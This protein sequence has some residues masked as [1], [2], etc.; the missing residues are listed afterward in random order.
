DLCTAARLPHLLAWHRGA[1][2]RPSWRPIAGLPA[3]PGRQAKWPCCRQLRLARSD[4][5]SGK[6]LPGCRTVAH[7]WASSRL[8]SRTSSPT[9][10]SA[11]TRSKPCPGWS[12][13]TSPEQGREPSDIAESLRPTYLPANTPSR[14]LH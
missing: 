4:L 6:H 5:T 12:R 9:R 10:H 11:S 14:C 13:Y 7:H 8:P 3:V 1:Q 2:D